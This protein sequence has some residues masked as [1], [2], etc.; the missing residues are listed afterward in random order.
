MIHRSWP[1]RHLA[2]ASFSWFHRRIAPIAESMIEG[3][4]AE[5]SDQPLISAQSWAA[6]GTRSIRTAKGVVADYLSLTKPGVMSLLLVTE[7]LAMVTAARGFPGWGLSMA[8]IAGGALASG[9]ASAINCWFDRDIDAVMGRT[10]NRPVPAGRISAS[11]AISF[12]VVLSA[13]AFLTFF[14]LV[15]PLAAVLSL[16]GGAFYVFIYTFWLKR[17]TKENIVIGGAAGAVPP[18]V[19]WAAVTHSVG[20]VG[21][22][23]FVLVFLWTPPHFW[24]LSLILKRDYQA[25][26]VPMRPVVVGVR[27]TKTAIVGYA[28]LMTLASCSLAIWLGPAQL[29]VSLGLGLPFMLLS[30]GVLMEREGTGRARLLFLF[31]I[32]Y[33]FLFFLGTALVAVI[34]H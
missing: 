2:G 10:R 16:A 31:S 30:V 13:T 34:A 17:A 4:P 18:L 9:G 29:I 15:N 26:A 32:A 28:A 25:V 19:G 23:L 5:A 24:A 12:G 27:R 1:R 21:V 3:V 14:F 33:L 11:R 8:A 6:P 22:A 20:L 7:F